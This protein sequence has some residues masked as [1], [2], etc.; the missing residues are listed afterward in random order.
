MIFMCGHGMWVWRVLD[1][2]FQKLEAM[3]MGGQE[4]HEMHILGEAQNMHK[5]DSLYW[6]GGGGW[7]GGTASIGVIEEG[8]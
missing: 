7:G 6:G 3:H 5:V 4:Y 2:I 8:R 1:L